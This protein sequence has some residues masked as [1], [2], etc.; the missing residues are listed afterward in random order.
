MKKHYLFFILQI[1]IISTGLSQSRDSIINEIYK[2]TLKNKEIKKEVIKIGQFL[3][4]DTTN[5]YFPFKEYRKVICYKM[6][7]DFFSFYCSKHL[8]WAPFFELK[9]LDTITNSFVEKKIILTE[10]QIIKLL[11]II[12]NPLN[13]LW[14]GCE[15]KPELRF[16]FY[17]NNDL[18]IAVI[19]SG[20][21]HS[22]LLTNP[23]SLLTKWGVLKSEMKIEYDTLLYDFGVIN[24][25]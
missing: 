5:K 21:S 25:K 6:N 19:N 17:D 9:K 14:L 22:V 10:D 15:F 20:N 2:D 23:N 12:N 11:R 13:F 18:I 4:S 3:E 16:E 24:S 1:I 7:G 8:K